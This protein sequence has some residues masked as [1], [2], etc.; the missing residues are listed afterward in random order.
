MPSLLTPMPQPTKTPLWEKILI[1]VFVAVLGGL[2]LYYVFGI[3]KNNPSPSTINANQ[4]NIAIGNSGTVNQNLTVNNPTPSP[5]G[6]VVTEPSKKENDGFYH[7]QATIQIGVVPGGKAPILAGFTPPQGIN[8]DQPSVGNSGL[9][10]SG[11]LMGLVQYDWT[12]DCTSTE[13]IAPGNY[14]KQWK[15]SWK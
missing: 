4:S 7:T 1:G 13:P 9:T 3:G 10:T 14:G 12:T 11:A 15:I 5:I 6:Q 2:I 8:C